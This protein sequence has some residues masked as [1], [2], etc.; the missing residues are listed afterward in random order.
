ML[1]FRFNAPL[2]FFNAPY[3]KRQAQAAIAA[4]GPALKWF[5]LDALPVT[6]VD[7][8]GIYALL[9]LERDLRARRAELVLAGRRTEL[10]RWLE[11]RGLLTQVPHVAHFPT[12]RQAVRALSD[13]A[14]DAHRPAPSSPAP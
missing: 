8:T 1:L 3:F 10:R 13:R 12:L 2:V 4:A 14:G 6:Q 7:V 11:A 5:V 9:D